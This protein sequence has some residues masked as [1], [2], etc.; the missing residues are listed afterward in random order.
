MHTNCMTYIDVRKIG[1]SAIIISRGV[2]A[3]TCIVHVIVEMMI[4]MFDSSAIVGSATIVKI[5]VVTK[6]R[7]LLVI[8]NYTS[9]VS[10]KRPACKVECL[11]TSLD[12][13]WRVWDPNPLH[14][15]VVSTFLHLSIAKPI[16]A[17]CL[18]DPRAM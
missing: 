13:V 6:Y 16:Y 1:S 2:V 8:R 7:S 14:F 11:R 4:V 3:V 18:S 9:F 17:L 5:A 10:V 15:R 12:F